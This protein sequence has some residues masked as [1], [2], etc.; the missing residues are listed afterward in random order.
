MN[1]WNNIVGKPYLILALGVVLGGGVIAANT[2]KPTTQSPA[3]TSAPLQFKPAGYPSGTAALSTARDL[4]TAMANLAESASA[5]VV[6]IRDSREGQGAQGSG[7]IYTT[8]GWI[9]TND[10][11]V[12][13]AKT[14][15]VTMTDGR[16]F[17][18]TVTKA[19]D[20]QIDL[21]VIKIQAK[22]LP[23]LSLANSVDVR[24]GQTSIAIGSPFGLQNSVTIGHVSAVE[25]PNGVQDPRAGQRN[26]TGMLQTD[27]S[28]NPGNS[29]GPLIN[30]D[31]QVI[32]V[33][34]TIYSMTGSSAGIG[35]S[36]A[37]NLVKAVAD[38]MIRT[39]KFERGYLGAAL[40]DVK[41]FRQKELGIKGGALIV[42]TRNG[43]PAFTSGLRTGDVILSVDGKPAV[44]Q[45]EV[46]IQFYKKNPGDSVALVY[47]RDGKQPTSTAK[48]GVPSDFDQKPMSRQGPRNLMP[49]PDGTFPE[50]TPPNRGNE[51]QAPRVGRPRLGVGVQSLDDSMRKQF[52]I[53]A[54]ATGVLVDSVMP[55]SFADKV[56]IQT[57]DVITSINGTPVDTAAKLVG[58]MSKVTWGDTITLSFSHYE[59]GQESTQSITVPF[60]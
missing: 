52:N 45:L 51:N 31:G 25:R 22:D 29:G 15:Y 49:M 5:A 13:N 8:D 20:P 32:G 46:R 6:N 41:P 33:N 28:I 30:I 12:G 21:A 3:V 36:I 59:K 37:S 54:K 2:L 23:T 60:N 17:E 48:L 1:L 43:T 26:Y 24:P 57:G 4:D 27:T 42:E 47:L 18:G 55:G 11:V 38:K 34:S 19:N 53:P 58:V 35:F 44:N 14:V 40:E 9:I 56:G 50:L 10:H 16:E 39:G 7:F